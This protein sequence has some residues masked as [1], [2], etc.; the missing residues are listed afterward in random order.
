MTLPFN[1]IFGILCFLHSFN[2]SINTNSIK[3]FNCSRNYLYKD[4]IN[5][6]FLTLN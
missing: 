1:I 2:N 3:K 6:R 5:Y 4:D